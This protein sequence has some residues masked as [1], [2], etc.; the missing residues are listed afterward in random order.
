MLLLRTHP[1]GAI[2]DNAVLEGSEAQN[3]KWL[4]NDLVLSIKDGSSNL[5]TSTPIDWK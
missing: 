4:Y 1:W 5:P 3:V 2:K